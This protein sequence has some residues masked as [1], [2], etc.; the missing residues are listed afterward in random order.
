VYPIGRGSRWR[1]SQGPVGGR[2]LLQSARRRRSRAGGDDGRFRWRSL[3]PRALVARR[4][5]E[6]RRPH[7][8]LVRS[9][10]SAFSAVAL[11]SGR[12]GRCGERR[13]HALSVGVVRCASSEVQRVALARLDRRRAGRAGRRATALASVFLF[14]LSPRRLRPPTSPAFGGK[15]AGRGSR[16]WLKLTVSYRC[17]FD[18]AAW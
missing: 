6:C 5:Y 8:Y 1:A 15:E 16:R 2:Q 14:R 11:L 18:D 3:W 7:G 13:G 10:P 12:A 9:S 4:A 17:T